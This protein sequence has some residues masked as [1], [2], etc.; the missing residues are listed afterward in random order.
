M[1]RYQDVR[2]VD[3]LPER[4]T[5]RATSAK[6]DAVII[7]L[8]EHLPSLTLRQ[9]QLMLREKGIEVSLNTIRSRL[10]ELKINFRP[11][12]PKRLSKSE[13]PKRQEWARENLQGD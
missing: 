8:F 3:D 7:R 5:A 9:A 11:S 6:E 1:K 4:G 12:L 10:H 13:G 2:N